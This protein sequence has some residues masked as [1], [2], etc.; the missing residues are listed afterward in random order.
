[1]K[2]VINRKRRIVVKIICFTIVVNSV[3]IIYREVKKTPY[4]VS[5]ENGVLAVDQSRD[6][7]ISSNQEIRHKPEDTFDEDSIEETYAIETLQQNGEEDNNELED[8][9]NEH[10]DKIMDQNV[11]PALIGMDEQTA[12]T[13]CI[14]SGYTYNIEYYLRG[15]GTVISQSP[16]SSET[17]TPGGN[18]TI[19]IGLPEN[20]FSGK[21]LTLINQ[22]RETLG[23]AGLSLS[24][25][26]CNA[27]D[28]LAKENVNSIDCVR[29]DGSHWSSV[30]VENGIWLSDGVYT[31]RN[32]ITSL[33]DANLRI[34]YEGNSYGE[35]N[36]LTPSYTLIGIA[37]SPNNMIVM[38]IGG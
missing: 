3:L 30:L 6:R 18:I 10:D 25:Q 26:L 4:I 5:R 12:I 38:I 7:I 29:P 36:L 14:Q 33:S 31:T 37:Y 23:L 19:N 15:N 35:G 1:M 22:K 21:L 9:R 34:K 8:S 2:D 16:T 28:I 24:D 27:C 11:V 32:N 13:V 17:I 20:E